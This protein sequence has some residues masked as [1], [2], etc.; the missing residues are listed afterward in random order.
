MVFNIPHIV[1]KEMICMNMKSSVALVMAGIGGT[2]LYQQIK[3][4]K[5]QKNLRNMMN[6]KIKAMD[7][8]ED[9]I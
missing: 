5:L 6:A 8:L 4:G 2:L 3:S 1:L 7:N 9:M